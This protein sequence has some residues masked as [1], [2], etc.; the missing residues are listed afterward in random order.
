MVLHRLHLLQSWNVT[1]L[2]EKD[3]SNI[4]NE[5]IIIYI[6][7]FFAFMFGSIIEN[8]HDFEGSG[9]LAWKL[10]FPMSKVNC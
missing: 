8:V 6:Y 5:T 4:S 1:L 9:T 3:N 7:K 10:H 2:S